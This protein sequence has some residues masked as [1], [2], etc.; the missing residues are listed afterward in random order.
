MRSFLCGVLDSRS[1]RLE[2]ALACGL[3]QLNTLFAGVES[4]GHESSFFV[5]GSE[6][7]ELVPGVCNDPL[8]CPQRLVDQGRED[9]LGGIESA[10]RSNG[11]PSHQSRRLA[12]PR[13]G[14][15][16]PSCHRD[17][18]HAEHHEEPPPRP[19]RS[20]PKACAPWNTCSS[21]DR[22]P[23]SLQRLRPER[24]GRGPYDVV[25][26]RSLCWSGFARGVSSVCQVKRVTRAPG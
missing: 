6:F 7:E 20:S 8:D 23:K 21:S 22:T 10:F 2:H 17:T 15:L 16:L 19:S 13:R 4:G 12:R 11:G 5:S 18:G 26:P 9:R 1:K 24:P 3:D 14:R 25:P